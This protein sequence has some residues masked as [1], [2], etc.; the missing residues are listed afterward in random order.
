M[1]AEKNDIKNQK[2]KVVPNCLKWREKWLKLIFGF[3][4]PPPP[5]KKMGLNKFCSTKSKLF[6]I[7]RNGEKIGQTLIFSFLTQ[8]FVRPPILQGRGRVKNSKNHFQPIF[9]PFQAI[10]NPPPLFWGEGGGGM[11]IFFLIICVILMLYT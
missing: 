10:W 7:A 6:Q 2:I 11:V 4:N 8:F 1:G 9:S 5:P 3:F